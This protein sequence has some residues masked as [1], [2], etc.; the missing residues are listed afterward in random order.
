MAQT[1]ARSRLKT[2]DKTLAKSRLAARQNTTKANQPTGQAMAKDLNRT[3]F[4]PKNI[5]NKRATSTSTFHSTK[6]PSLPATF[7]PSLANSL[8]KKKPLTTASQHTFADL[9]SQ[10][11]KHLQYSLALL[12]AILLYFILYQGMQ[13]FYPEQIQNLGLPN[14]YFPFFALFFL[15]NFLFFCFLFVKKRFAFFLACLLNVILFFKVQAIAFDWAAV[16]VL[17]ASALIVTWIFFGNFTF[18]PPSTQLPAQKRKIR[19]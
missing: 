9:Q 3:H 12:L 17:F 6:A 1:K 13:Y 15:A 5:L 19:I 2:S 8:S 16:V 4:W 11:H 14:S 7:L 18:H 10:F